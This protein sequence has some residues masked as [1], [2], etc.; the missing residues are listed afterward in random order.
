M[1]SSPRVWAIASKRTS[2]SEGPGLD[3]LDGSKGVPHQFFGW[4]SVAIEEEVLDDRIVS[5]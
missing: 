5:A 4:A 3:I 2:F 1:A